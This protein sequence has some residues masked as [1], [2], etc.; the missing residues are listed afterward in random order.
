MPKKI[1][2]TFILDLKD[3]QRDSSW[4]EKGVV[5]H[6]FSPNNK[7]DKLTKKVTD[8][9]GEISF[10]FERRFK[11]VNTGL[12]KKI[13]YDYDST[14]EDESIIP[15]QSHIGN[16]VL[17]GSLSFKNP[18]K[19]IVNAI[20]NNEVGNKDYITFG[21]KVVTAIYQHSTEVISIFRDL[22]RQYWITKLDKWDSRAMSISTYCRNVLHLKYSID[23]GKT[24]NKFQPDE[25]KHIAEIA[26]IVGHEYHEYIS[27][28]EWNSIKNLFSNSYSP[29]L[30]SNLISN[31][32][33]TCSKGD[34]QKG[35]VEAVT[36]LELAIASRFKGNQKVNKTIEKEIQA[37]YNLPLKSQL[38][39]IGIGLQESNS[40]L[41]E[42]GFEAIDIRN[43]IVHEAYLPKSNDVSLL[44]EL[45]N[46][47]S[48]LIKEPVSKF[49]PESEAINVWSDKM[50]KVYNERNKN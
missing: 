14:L 48:R 26:G 39:I 31:S 24:W 28:P 22:Y 11:L 50:W 49:P 36:A 45:L 41:I 42:S 33:R 44:Y 34:L 15:K 23:N 17:F 20:K 4:S 35:F 25:L 21:K 18:S 3:N 8:F 12:S 19:E 10:W 32:H 29:S 5:F 47:I 2:F 40:A 46:L 43:K 7:E 27:E 16:E 1:D 38:S 30:I 6:R 37:F 9:E 13:F